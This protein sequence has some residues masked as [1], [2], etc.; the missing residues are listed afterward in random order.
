MVPSENTY[1]ALCSI[2]HVQQSPSVPSPPL[3]TV[4]LQLLSNVTPPSPSEAVKPIKI[5]KLPFAESTPFQHGLAHVGRTTRISKPLNSM[6]D[7]TFLLRQ[8]TRYVY[9][10]YKKGL[11]ISTHPIS[12]P[13][14]APSLPSP[15]PL[16]LPF[17]DKL[18][19][20]PIP[21][22]LRPLDHL[23]SFLCR[24]LPPSLRLRHRDH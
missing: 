18:L 14:P 17:I 24:P 15:S 12:Y 13:P 1:A 16:Q 9:R 4:A 5:S 10:G 19:P 6:S 3:K 21:I 7:D 22:L 23:Y 20:L 2:A 11:P 8:L